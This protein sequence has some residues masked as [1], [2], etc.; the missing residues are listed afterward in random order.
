MG[1][2]LASTSSNPTV[3]AAGYVVSQRHVGC[4]AALEADDTPTMRPS[5][6]S[7]GC[8]RVEGEQV[9]FPQ[10]LQPA[11]EIFPAG[12]GSYCRTMPRRQLC[13]T[14]PLSR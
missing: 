6:V 8:L 4:L 7:A 13:G 11:F 5:V 9:D 1:L 2:V 3:G 14:G 12:N 10:F